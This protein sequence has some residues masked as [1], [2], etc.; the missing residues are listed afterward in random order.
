MKQVI[1]GLLVMVLVFLSCKKDDE[2]VPPPPPAGFQWPAGTGE[3]APNTSGSTFVYQIES[4]TPVTIDSFTYTVVKDTT[5]NGLTFKKL[6]SNKPYLAANFYCNYNAGI[7]TEITYN[8]DFQGVT[9]PVLTQTVL[10]D[11]VPVTNSWNESLN[12]T[13]SGFQIP[14]TFTYTIMQKDFIKN[15]L[16]KD[17]A[18]TIAVKQVA[19]IPSIIATQLGLPFS[20][21]QVDNFFSKGAGLVQREA[22]NTIIKMKRF[23]V[24]K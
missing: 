14:V 23:N 13:V 24:I 20:S 1:W 16:G 12:V 22:P 19:S 6:E 21:I 10:K 7:R 4:G 18:A 3:Y 8:Y 15:I 5:I 11:N 2:D 9:I 17:Y